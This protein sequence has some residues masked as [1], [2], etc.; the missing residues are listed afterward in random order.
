[1]KKR[2]FIIIQLI[3]AAVE[4]ILLFGFA[5]QDTDSV[6]D[7]VAVNEVLQS[8][9]A[10][11]DRLES[12]ENRTGLAYVVLDDTGEVLYRTDTGLSESINA[13]VVHR[14][15]ILDVESGG[16]VVGKL[17]LSN[18]SAEFLKSRQQTVLLAVMAL[19]LVQW[20]VCIGY[21]IYL[22]RIVV[23][24][25]RRL[26]D[27]AR[28]VAGGNLD[29]PLAM[30][31]GN[32]F[33]A[34]TESFDIMRDE[35]KKARLAEAKANAEKKE[36]VA[37]LSHDIRTPVASIKAASEV[38]AALA[39][40][41]RIKGNYGQIIRKA[42]Q[43]DTLVNNL[44][45]ATLEELEQLTVAPVD[46]ESRELA[47]MLESA[48]Y[49][50]W[51]KIPPIPECLLYGDRLR[52]QQVFDNIFANAY[53]YGRGAFRGGNTLDGNAAI[54]ESGAD[55]GS[56]QRGAGLRGEP[57]A[58]PERASGG[59]SGKASSLEG[60]IYVTMRRENRF[61]AVCIE[62]C[63]GGVDPEELPLLKEKFRRGSN[64]GNKEG[65]GLGLYISDY[66]LRE[67]GGELL[68]ENG[69]KGLRV[70]VA[71]RLSGS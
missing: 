4:T 58:E 6:Q 5:L 70:T 61:L 52:L 12:H 26:K 14:D 40:N 30:D 48:D 32:L 13:A 22:D 25:F 41:D 51:A 35:L 47:E 28:R 65:A 57:C 55:R 42:D 20:S 36:L 17:I 56:C 29:I 59:D 71:V 1:M 21:G 9:E 64:A 33:G 24:P 43:I 3:V 31:R 50:G 60:K 69:E 27:F 2:Y 44:F 23:R 46:M 15:T 39:E 68:V 62:D 8:V 38:G 37:K 34:F 67:M 11:W 49:F 18:D 63:G 16:L 10:D 53:K 7:A 45:T 54:Q 66:F 19:M